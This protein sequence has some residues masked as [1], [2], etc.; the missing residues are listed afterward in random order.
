M[1]TKIITTSLFTFL[2]F[3]NVFGQSIIRESVRNGDFSQGNIPGDFYS[4]LF[5]ADSI[6][7]LMIS[8][9]LCHMSTG[10]KYYVGNNQDVYECN[11]TIRQGTKF[12]PD[13]GTFGM[14]GSADNM[15]F[16]DAVG[17]SPVVWG[18][19]VDVFE[20]QVYTISFWIN[21][22]Y[23]PEP[24]IGATINGVNVPLNKSNQIELTGEM[25][26]VRI[27]NGQV[28]T[29]A[30]G[31]GIRDTTI[32]TANW[33]QY[34]GEWTSNDTA[35]AEIK[36]RPYGDANLSTPTGMMGY[37]F[38]LDNI[39]LINS[40]QNIHGANAYVIDFNLMD[41]INLCETGGEIELNPHIPLGEESNASVTWYI[42]QGNDATLID[43]GSFSKTIT[44]PGYYTVNVDDPD[45][46]CVQGK[47]IVVV[48]D[49]EIDINDVELCMPSVVT[50][51]AGIHP[52][53]AFSID[54]TG[55][56]GTG[57]EG[58]YDVTDE[59]T[60]TLTINPLNGHDG[61]SAVDTFDVVSFLPEIDTVTYC[62][63]GGVDVTLALNDG[64]NYKWSLNKNMSNPIGTGSSV[65]YSV[66]DGSDSAI[67]VWI[68]NA[69]TTPV[70]TIG[71]NFASVMS[72]YSSVLTT[73]FTAHKNIVIKSAIMGMYAWTGDCT[74]EG[75]TNVT[76]ELIDA[77]NNDE[78]VSSTVV[79]VRC[80]ATENIYLNLHVPDGKYKLK[81]TSSAEFLT[82]ILFSGSAELY[83]IDEVIDI[84]GYSAY[85][86]GA[87]GNMEIEESNACDP[88]PII[89]IPEYCGGIT[90]IEGENIDDAQEINIYPNPVMDYI[91][92][93][94]EKESKIKR[95]QLVNI[96]G[97]TLYEGEFQSRISVSQLETG[98]YFL[99]IKNENS[100][101]EKTVKIIKR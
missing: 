25:I 27:E 68:Q 93:Q 63:G 78:L 89:L 49:I 37:D 91:Q 46:A 87:F 54:W 67:H 28:I 84:T 41:T 66:P 18:Q 1:R 74:H 16:V 3:S 75:K 2:L 38:A 79:E 11:G 13:W 81:A 86:Y 69:E 83:S 97:E 39:S 10:G 72:S 65:N 31:V 40:C 76:V 50:L 29:D 33:I 100:G 17:G 35:M 5:D 4:D 48:E 82:S 101:I 61:C 42:G 15:M 36:L 20:N 51:D 56:S 26:R 88:V 32:G 23:S 90:N 96:L 60:H 55:P 24:F 59:G 12:S 22:I 92:I 21:I 70:G 71:N 64:K 30:N 47:S 95:L 73:D 19:T 45:N 57:S 99:K 44:S 80:G 9:N 43:S 98:I 62:D 58:V 34:T 77:L 94:T 8:G 6:V 53:S 14:T 85:T 52:S 7:N